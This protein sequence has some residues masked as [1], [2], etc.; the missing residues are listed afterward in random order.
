MRKI[1]LVLE[2][3]GNE[4]LFLGTFFIGSLRESFH[5]FC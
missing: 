5:V 3:Q 4:R 1:I 2:K